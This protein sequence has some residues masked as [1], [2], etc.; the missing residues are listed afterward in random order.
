MRRSRRVI[1]MTVLALM[2]VQCSSGKGDDEAQ[3]RVS[4]E[5]EAGLARYRGSTTTTSTTTTVPPT[6]TT[7]V[8]VPPTTVPVTSPPVPAQDVSTGACGG[9]L[10]PCWIMMRESGG[11]IRAQNPDSSASGKWQMLDSTWAGYGGYAHAKD[12]PEWV[13]DAKARTMGLCNWQPPNYCAG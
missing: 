8:T 6:T 10:P 13:Q 11:D 9:D 2:S 12:A 3:P 5:N 4:V 7:T 1:L